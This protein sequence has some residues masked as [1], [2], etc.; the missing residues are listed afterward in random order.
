MFL[1]KNSL[2]YQQI[3][4]YFHLHISDLSQFYNNQFQFGLLNID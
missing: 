3:Q 1:Q 2:A 4:E